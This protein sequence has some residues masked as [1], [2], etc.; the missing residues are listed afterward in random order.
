MDEIRFMREGEK[1]MSV[2]IPA[3]A[4]IDRSIIDEVVKIGPDG[5]S[6]ATTFEEREIAFLVLQG[7][8]IVNTVTPLITGDEIWVG[9]T[10]HNVIDL[11]FLSQTLLYSPQCV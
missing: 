10:L 4:D 11:D 8:A 2:I 7:A 6:V 1:L 3:G 5:K 9:D